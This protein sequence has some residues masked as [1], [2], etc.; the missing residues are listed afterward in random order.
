MIN[1]S[2]YSK[3]FIIILR[4]IYIYI[5]ICAW[6]Y[7]IFCESLRDEINRRSVLSMYLLLSSQI[8][9]MTKM[10]NMNYKQNDVTL[11]TCI[12]SK[13]NDHLRAYAVWIKKTHINTLSGNFAAQS[14]FFNIT[15]KATHVSIKYEY[16]NQCKYETSL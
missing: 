6:I 16:I 8:N 1:F 14:I 13:S 11:K 10:F 15:S 9:S 12:T 4:C 2:T 3:N 5:Y 7:I